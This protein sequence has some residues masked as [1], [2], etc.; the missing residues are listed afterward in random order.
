MKRLVAFE[1]QVFG[2]AG[3]VLGGNVGGRPRIFEVDAGEML[4]ALETQIVA[5]TEG[6]ART[7][8]LPPEDAYGPIDPAGFRSFPVEGIPEDARQ[9][10]RKVVGR[11][12]DGREDLFD[13][14]ALQD[15]QVVLDMNHPLAGQTLRF[16]IKVLARASD[17]A[18]LAL[19]TRMGSDAKP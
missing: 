11:A 17:E 9:V 13:V 8:E 5:M 7:I 6:E 15:D 18:K 2:K 10:G 16:E 19:R 3:E 1:F 12:P 14:V 4:P